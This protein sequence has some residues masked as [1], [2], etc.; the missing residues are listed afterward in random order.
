M[1][2][3][4]QFGA[5]LVAALLAASAACATDSDVRAIEKT[6]AAWLAATNDKDITR[7]S[8]FLAKDPYFSPAD[9]S[10]LTGRAAVVA[11]YTKSF[12]DPA[13]SLDCEQL[14]VQVSKSKDMAWSRGVCAGTFTLPDGNK[15]QGFSR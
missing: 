1:R 12:S 4:W 8:S 9:S 14:D 3:T 13:F 11:Y 2:N 5:G 10:P 6:Y 7:W 15:G